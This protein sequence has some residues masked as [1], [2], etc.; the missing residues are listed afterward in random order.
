MLSTVK[1]MISRPR[2]CLARCT[3]FISSLGSSERN[4]DFG[5]ERS[6]MSAVQVIHNSVSLDARGGRRA[7]S[8][9]MRLRNLKASLGTVGKRVRSELTNEPSDLL[10]GNIVPRLTKR[11]VQKF[12]VFDC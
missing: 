5:L 10:G 9:S 8:M 3:R 4:L 12:C 2:F 1:M 6:Q 7:F 11:P